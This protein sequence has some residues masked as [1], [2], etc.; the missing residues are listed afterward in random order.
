VNQPNRLFSGGRIDRDRPL[1]F[2]FDGREHTGF[3]GDSLA[4]A[5]LAADVHLVGRSF[6][7]HRPRG[8][9]SAGAEE[10]NALVQLE[11][12]AWTQPNLRATQ[13]EL[14]EGL[15]ASSQN[16]WPSLRI[17]V[18]AV[19]GLL[20]R[21]L[22]AGFYYKTFMWPPRLWMT[23]EAAI[24]RAAGLGRAPEQPD[25]DVYDK[26][27]AHC[28]VLVAGA[29]PAGLSAALAAARSG[30][31]VL[32]ADEQPHPGGALLGSRE[33]VD[34]VA[35][36]DWAAAVT[37]ELMAM[38]NVRLLTRTQVF[39]YFDHNHLGLVERLTDHLPPGTRPG[40]A[41]QRLWKVRAKQVVLATGAHER[42]L[43]FRNNDLP[44]IMLAG[45]ARTYVNRYA[46]RPGRRVVVFGNND[47]AW[48]AALDLSDAGAVVCMVDARQESPAAL[49]EAATRRG[50]DVLAGHGVVAAY[51]ARQRV[52]RVEVAPLTADGRGL[53]GNRR[54]MS[55]DLVCVSGG[56]SPVVHLH[57]QSGARVVWDEG[58]ACFVPG[59]AVQAS[60]VAGAANGTFDLDFVLS[61]GR[62]AGKA[63]AA[64]AGF[65][66]RTAA[67]APKVEARRSAPPLALWQV[68]LPPGGRA[69]KSFVDLQNDVT[70]ADIRLAARE[71]YRSVEHTKRYTTTGMGTD[72]GK[73]S[74]VNGLAILGDALG[75]AI[76][77]VG[78]TTFRPPY[79]PVT[80]GALAGRDLGALMDPVRR[81]PMHA[82]HE[83]NGALWED[84]GQWR[85]PWYYPRAGESMRAAVARECVAAR[86][87]VAILDATTLG[88]IDIRGPDAV[89][90]LNRVYTN[91]WKSLAVG[92]CRY[93]L[94]CGEDGMVFD[95]GVT[96][97]LDEDR[98]LMHTTSGN[99]ARVLAWLEEWLQTEWPD[100]R[101]YCNSVTEH[102]ATASIS[103][104]HARRL[105][106]ELTRD[107]DLDPEAFPFMSWRAGTVA[108]LPARVLRVS[109]TG[110]LCYEI[111]VPADYGMAL[112]TALM[113]AGARY[114]IT[115]FGTETMHVLRA[116]KGF[117]IAGQET[118]G[119]VTPLDLGMERMCS[120]AKDW[121]GRRS[122]ARPD[123]Q[124]A[125]R[126]QLVGLRT[127]DPG[128]VLP[129]GAQVVEAF[130]PEPPVPMIGHVTSSYWSENLGHSIALALV[131]GGRARMGQEVLLPL[132]KQL[133]RA[134]V[135]E[136][137][138]FDPRGER[139]N[140]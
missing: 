6:K 11:Q 120:R 83:A 103:G 46:V 94:M 124:R 75:R 79:T 29:G 93:G 58:R 22:P 127:E 102:W 116:E 81:T 8:I 69:H 37:A 71:G 99:A 135:C 53:A 76:P 95:D 98:Y 65:R 68:P 82:W 56:W 128:L 40:L 115:P 87:A 136:P 86:R 62:E 18:G 123:S 24:R 110:E 54:P 118:D 106:A 126:K 19:N 7:Y 35:G 140:G 139:M 78:T 41:R 26:M 77:Q 4:S 30:A 38:G 85:R 113:N 63:A 114:G 31:R 50:V 137:A 84:V 9:V 42:P 59:Q 49:R 61:E 119:T 39:A 96:V 111:N 101:V 57:S 109:F 107:I 55:C 64:D 43:V 47:T 91:G 88:K 28:D 122:L 48:A 104:P 51:G 36:A 138:F 52:N 25:P 27:H 129:E 14:Y 15:S 131:C 20:S 67:A 134:N 132:D 117:I 33:V 112:W 23:Y 108:G 13:V 34:D 130:R 80:F 66:T 2:S 3:E 97:R 72:Q 90:L 121:I 1:A 92:R 5:L 32:L 89:V 60:R 44:G 70:A 12:G 16:R 74:N 45:A 133:V 21:L 125:D 73:T 10:P 17:D 105:L 100:L